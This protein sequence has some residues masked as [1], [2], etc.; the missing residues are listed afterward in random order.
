MEF[1]QNDGS[2]VTSIVLKK[3]NNEDYDTFV[4]NLFLS[5]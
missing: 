2:Q 4:E 5:Q 3:G 1:L